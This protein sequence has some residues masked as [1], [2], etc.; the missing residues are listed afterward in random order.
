MHHYRDVPMSRCTDRLPSRYPLCRLDRLRPLSS[1]I[2]L[3]LLLLT[4]LGKQ[5]C[6]AWGGGGI[7]Q[8][9]P[10]PSPDD[11]D[12]AAMT[13]P[14]SLPMCS[15]EF[16]PASLP[17][18]A[19]QPTINIP[20]YRPHFVPLSSVPTQLPLT[21]DLYHDAAAAVGHSR[22][23]KMLRGGSGGADVIRQH[24]PNAFPDHPD[25][26]A[27]TPE[28]LP[29]SRRMSSPDLLPPST[30]QPTITIPMSRCPDVPTASRYKDYYST[31]CKGIRL[32][33]AQRND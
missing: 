6:S 20:M 30:S 32:G 2:M 17:S 7:R 8:Y 15:P 18:P 27:M 31:D 25:L 3:L 28:R 1:I 16:F 9:T 5:R 29:A 21:S 12:S 26:A 10:N 24:T 22:E 13:P 19:P 11:H 14:P 23:A 33:I 4:P